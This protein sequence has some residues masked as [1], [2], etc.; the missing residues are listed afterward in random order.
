MR[1]LPTCAFECHAKA[2]HYACGFIR[3]LAAGAGKRIT[4]V[5][6]EF[7]PLFAGPSPCRIG[8]RSV[9]SGTIRSPTAGPIAD[10]L[11]LRRKF[12]RAARH[13]HVF[14]ENTSATEHAHIRGIRR[15]RRSN[16]HDLSLMTPN[17]SSHQ[18]A[19]RLP[20]YQPSRVF[21]MQARLNVNLLAP[22]GHKALLG[23]QACGW[24]RHRKTSARTGQ[25]ARIWINGCAFC[26]AMHIADATRAG[27]RLH[28]LNMAKRGYTRTANAPHWRGPR[29]WR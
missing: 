14:A 5:V 8:Q 4:S 21:I 24:Q 26:I 7:P 6:V 16:A 29:R 19:I 23:L 10:D 28:L 20:S 3:R 17:E 22:N 13:R 25:N 15:G 1:S 12:R 2:A 18:P 9:L 27:R 11:P